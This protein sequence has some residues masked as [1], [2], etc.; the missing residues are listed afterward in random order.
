MWGN[1]VLCPGVA[2]GL[3]AQPGARRKSTDEVVETGGA[4]SWFV[5]SVAAAAGYRG[6]K[7]HSAAGFEQ[8]DSGFGNSDSG[9]KKWR[10]ANGRAARWAG[11]IQGLED[12]IEPTQAFVA[13][14]D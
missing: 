12:R 3:V 14:T 13:R 4:S 9:Q 7:E 8:D 2:G 1:R 6:G 5:A 11:R 10:R